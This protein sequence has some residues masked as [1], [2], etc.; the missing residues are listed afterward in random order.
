MRLLPCA[1]AGLLV[2]LDD[3]AE[4][5]GLHAALRDDPPPG[6]VDLVP[7]ARTLLLRLDPARADLAQVEQAVR[8]ASP[9]H[10][11]RGRGEVVDIPV[12]YDG[13]DLAD[14]AGHLGLTPAEVVAAHTG[15]EWTVAFGGF[16]PGFGYLT[17]EVWHFDVPRRAESRT[18]VPSGAVGLAGGFSGVYPR[19]SP[20]G[21]QLIGH[22][23]TVLWDIAR[24]PPALLRPGVR[25]R[26]V[27]ATP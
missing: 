2:E 25:V 11:A 15:A 3:L 5:T 18:T 10:N 27:E 7:A 14:V 23:R 20:G 19:A 13:A 26:F 22:T 1:D 21:W 24:D 17:G 12:T 4:V 9:R 8:G 6:V 16:A